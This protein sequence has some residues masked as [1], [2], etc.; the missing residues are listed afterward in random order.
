TTDRFVAVMYNNN[1]QVIPGNTAAV[2]NEL[3]FKGLNQFG[4][5]FLSR[6]QVSQMRNSLLQ[7]LTFIDSPGIL[8]GTKQINRGYDF[9]R[10]IRWFVERSDLVLLLFDSH[11]LDISDEFKLAIRTLAGHED[12]VR[13]VLNK[14]DQISQ[15]ELM[16]V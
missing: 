10:V 2:S 14:C 13:I 3:P 5:K 12:K 11:K 6:F 15:Q 1:N 8:S 9:G 4:E 7:N 16:R